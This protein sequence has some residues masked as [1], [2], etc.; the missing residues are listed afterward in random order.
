MKKEKK[1]SRRNGKKKEK[2][3]FNCGYLSA[4]SSQ[5]LMTLAQ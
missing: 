5:L 1:R 4:F 3:I 2:Q